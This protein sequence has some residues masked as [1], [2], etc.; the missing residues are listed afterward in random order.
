[1]GRCVE[2]DYSTVAAHLVGSDELRE[3]I[4]QAAVNGAQPLAVIGAL[5]GV[6]QAS[7]TGIPSLQTKNILSAVVQVYCPGEP[8]EGQQT[9]L[10]HDVAYNNDV[11][12]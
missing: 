8:S 4:L 2:E 6:K 12:I 11:C 1:M 3:L 7:A 10:C 9:R 5:G